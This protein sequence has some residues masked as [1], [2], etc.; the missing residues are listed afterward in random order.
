MVKPKKLKSLQKTLASEKSRVLLVVDECHRIGAEGKAPLCELSPESALG[1][2]ATPEVYGNPAGTNR[3]LELFSGKD[4]S[5]VHKFTLKEAL[6]KGILCPFYYH[7]ETV[8]LTKQ[9]QKRYDS[10]R[11]KMKWAWIKYLESNQQED[12]E[13]WFEL[14]CQSR[15]IIRGASEKIQA[16]KSFIQD[17]YD[18]GQRW[19]VYCDTIEMVDKGDREIRGLGMGIIPLI[20]HSEMDEF[21][22]EQVLKVFARDGGVLI[23]IRCLDEGV[24]IESISHGIILSSTTNP[25]EFIQRRG[26]LLRKHESKEFSEI[27]D[28]FALP[29]KESAKS[30]KFV[31]NEVFR[32]RELAEDSKNRISAMGKIDRIIR[33]YGIQED[34]STEEEIEDH[35]EQ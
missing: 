14:V 13:K 22:K 29:S 23:A 3:I 9:E 25:R 5:V 17:Y 32:A 28:A 20:Y 21:S 11:D 34:T 18:E 33:E 35:E 24:N 27:F 30:T 12:Y 19:I 4:G 31:Y 10:L 15:L 8:H 6:D 7:I 26:R 1:L 2:S 16:M